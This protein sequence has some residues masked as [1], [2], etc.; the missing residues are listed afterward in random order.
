MRKLIFYLNLILTLIS[1]LIIVLGY[2]IEND[3]DAGILP[4]LILAFY[5][6][7][8]AL[9]LTVFSAFHNRKLFIAFVVYWL[10]VFL[11][12]NFLIKYSVYFSLLIAA[13]H[14]SICYCIKTNSELN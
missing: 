5:Q 6:L 10:L 14:L 1:L 7:V 12:F 11:F 4:L 8:T 3:K 13:Y 9:G 2:S